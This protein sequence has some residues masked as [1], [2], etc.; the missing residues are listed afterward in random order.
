MTG[1]DDSGV[2]GHGEGEASDRLSVR[3]GRGRTVEGALDGGGLGKMRRCCCCCC[4]DCWAGDDGVPLG[5]GAGTSSSACSRSDVSSSDEVM[6]MAPPFGCEA[7]DAKARVRTSLRPTGDK[8]KERRTVKRFE[9]R[10]RPC[11]VA[12][13]AASMTKIKGSG[14]QAAAEGIN[15]RPRRTSL[16]AAEKSGAIAAV[17]HQLRMQR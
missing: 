3:T 8:V 9:D 12:R 6:V 16:D 7:A 14:P 4:C 11:T 1:V 2:R 13:A 15:D 10:S 5:E 17:G